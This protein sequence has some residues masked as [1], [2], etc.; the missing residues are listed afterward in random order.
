MKIVYFIDHL[1]PDGSQHV[2]RQ[3]V[4]AMAARGHTQAVVCLNDS[5]DEALV[6]RLR[7]AGA[8]VWVVGKRALATG[9]LLAIWL[10]LRHRRFDTA[11]T[12]LLY[13]DVIGRVLA[14][15]A[16]IPRVVTSIQT[17]N[18]D[19]SAL[20]RALV[21]GTI[22]LA[23]TVLIPSEEMRAFVAE[24][25]GA[26]HERLVLM[27]HAVEV[28][29]YRV[30]MEREALRAELGLAPDV[31][32]IG[33][34]ARLFP[35]KGHDVLLDAL[36]TL[37]EARPHL[38]IAGVG[39]LEGALRE[40]A[41]RLGI[42]SHVHFGGYRRDVPRLLGALDLYVHSSR[43]EG[44]SLAV[45]EAMAAGCPVV[46]TVVDGS[47]ELIEDGVHGWL[48][49]PG[50]A[51]ALARALGEALADPAEAR[52]RGDAAARRAAERYDTSIMAATWERVAGDGHL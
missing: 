48:V 24:V 52:R 34:V 41:R 14:R 21:R 31:R 1:R 49:P 25:E 38:L 43:W 4:E 50:D 45:I 33:M 2:L 42:E 16:G 27:Q 22:G 32:V 12:L 35:Q 19:Y 23:D 28:A 29:R 10:W 26:P 37:G 46:A 30:P 13:A 9:G 44:M 36:A 15:L 20:Q 6:A 17:R 11:L 5:V 47:R 51:A 40:R 8:E 18:V 3:L 7:G 39:E